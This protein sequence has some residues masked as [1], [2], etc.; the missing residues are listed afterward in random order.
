ML[1]AFVHG[2]AQCGMVY[3]VDGV[4][5][6]TTKYCTYLQYVL[7]L[8]P[9]APQG[10]TVW[11]NIL[12]CKGFYQ[13]RALKATLVF[14]ALLFSSARHCKAVGYARVRGFLARSG[15]NALAVLVE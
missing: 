11:A 4:V 14:G 10:V 2:Q 5:G 9:I 7:E 12:Q 6:F 13:I 8:Q 3:A 1:Y 15:C